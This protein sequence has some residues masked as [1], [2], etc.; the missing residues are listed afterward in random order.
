MNNLEENRSPSFEIHDENVPPLVPTPGLPNPNIE[1]GELDESPEG[2]QPPS[3]VP[4]NFARGY[5]L[6]TDT[7]GE[8]AII[9]G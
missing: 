2:R 9:G 8:G 7:N 3:I 6:Q 5:V 1:E 4:G